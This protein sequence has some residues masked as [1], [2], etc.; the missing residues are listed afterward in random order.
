MGEEGY[1]EESGYHEGEVQE[2]P[3]GP[4][5]SW[6]DSL[7]EQFRPTGCPEL[8]LKIEPADDAAHLPLDNIQITDATVP[9]QQRQPGQ[10]PR[11]EHGAKGQDHILEIPLQ[12][13]LPFLLL[14]KQQRF[15]LS[16][17]Q[18]V[19]RDDMQHNQICSSRH[20]RIS[21]MSRMRK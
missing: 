13:I 5:V 6:V 21:V 19:K 10:Q 12:Q 1:Y 14:L 16:V 18:L 8:P 15:Q 4:A 7:Q 20:S 17:L 9:F 11:R 2:E 3:V